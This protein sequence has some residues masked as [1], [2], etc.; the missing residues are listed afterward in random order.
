MPL[1][2]RSSSFMLTTHK[3]GLSSTQEHSCSKPF[4]MP[5]MGDRELRTQ[6][7]IPRLQVHCLVTWPREEHTHH[8]NDHLQKKK[9]KTILHRPLSTAW[10]LIHFWCFELAKVKP[11]AHDSS[12][13][14]SRLHYIQCLWP[15]QYANGLGN[16]AYCYT[17][18]AVSSLMVSIASTHYT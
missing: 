18:L 9:K 1:I 7:Q 3:V 14:H 4:L 15:G 10:T 12:Q 17:K 13:P 16:K 2:S 11:N 8:F 6:I 5:P